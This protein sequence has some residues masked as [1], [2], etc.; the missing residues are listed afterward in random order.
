[1]KIAAWLMLALILGVG[2]TWAIQGP[3][4]SE[5]PSLNLTT[6]TKKLVKEKM[7]DEFGDEIEKETW[8]KSFRIGLLDVTLPAVGGCTL[9]GLFLVWRIRRASKTAKKA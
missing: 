6:M 1:M 7:K 9:V 8:V 4:N 5:S 2:L 3:W